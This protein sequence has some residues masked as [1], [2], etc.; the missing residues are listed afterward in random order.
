[1]CVGYYVHFV[2]KMQFLFVTFRFEKHA[3]FDLRFLFDTVSIGSNQLMIIRIR[4][5]VRNRTP[6]LFCLYS[7]NQVVMTLA[8]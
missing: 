8:W 1:M 3:H 5:C 6:F 4:T 2:L 7:L